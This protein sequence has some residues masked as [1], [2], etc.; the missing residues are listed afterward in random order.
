MM[1]YTMD[2]LHLFGN[3]IAAGTHLVDFQMWEMGS[4]Y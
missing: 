3:T 2:N 4:C 1:K